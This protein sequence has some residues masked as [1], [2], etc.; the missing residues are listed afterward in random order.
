MEAVATQIRVHGSRIAVSVLVVL[1]A[2]AVCAAA[3]A[4]ESPQAAAVSTCLFSSGSCAIAGGSVTLRAAKLLP[5][6]T[7]TGAVV[8]ANDGNAPG[9]F[10][11]QT[12]TLVDRRGAGGGSLAKSLRVSVTDVTSGHAHRVYS[13]SFAGLHGVELGTLAPRAT[14]AYRVTVTFPDRDVDGAAFACSSLDW[15]LQWSAITAD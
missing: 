3:F 14:R 6:D 10:T 15:S 8:V 2:A 7:V 9:R 1:V 12:G 13:G 5:G 4:K 11:L